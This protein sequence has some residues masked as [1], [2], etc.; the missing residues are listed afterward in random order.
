MRLVPE[1]GLKQSNHR[2]GIAKMTGA[3]LIFALQDGISKHLS[4]TYNPMM[5]VLM[6]Y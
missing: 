4:V 1:T 5:V 2:L 3:S 6:R